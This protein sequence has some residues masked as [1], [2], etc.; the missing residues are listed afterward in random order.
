MSLNTVNYSGKKVVVGLTGRVASCVTALLLKKQGMNVIGLTIVTNSNDNFAEKSSYPTCHVEDLDK[1]KVF[2]EDLK[3]PFYATDGK[4]QFDSEVMDPLISNKLSGMANV[5]CFNCTKLRLDIL[6]HKMKEIKADYFAT[7]HFCKVQKNLTTNDFYI[8]SNNDVDS[9][10][11]YLLAGIDN[12]YLKHLL[13]P[14]GELKTSEV[15][16]IAEKYQLATLP[17]LEAT[18]FCFRDKES[19]M[20]AAKARIPKSM[21]RDGQVYNVDTDLIHGDHDGIISH[22]VTEP[23]TIFKGVNT[24]DKDLQIVGYDFVKARILIGGSANL[25]GKGIQ[26]IDLQLSSGLDMKKPIHCFI[27]SKYSKEYVK[28]NLFFKNNNS[29]LL[30]LDAELY[31]LIEGEYIVIFDKNSRNAKVVGLGKIGNIGEFKLVDRVDEFKSTESIESSS[32][33]APRLFKF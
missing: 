5:S 29:A 15:D 8:H 31:P 27:K 16:K 14:I 10:Q 7:G 22:Y 26:A 17:N 32:Q 11:A 23:G 25:S 1:I 33:K 19:Y 3:I 30:E 6:Y 13:L 28:V 2:C 9:D 4:S 21:K 24:N 18:G 20:N 12:K